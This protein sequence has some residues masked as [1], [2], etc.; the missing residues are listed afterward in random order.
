MN[1]LRICKPPFR[2]NGHESR[3]DHRS[4]ADRGIA[5]Q[6]EKHLGWKGSKNP[7]FKDLILEYRESMKSLN[8]HV[9]YLPKHLDK[10]DKEQPQQQLQGETEQAKVTIARRILE[11]KLKEQ[12]RSPEDIKQVIDQFNKAMQDPKNVEKLPSAE[13][14]QA[15]EIKYEQ[16]QSKGIER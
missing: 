6:P 3:V 14:K 9:Y 11:E 15:K 13:T 5:Q 7:Q 10:L 2:K 4:N 8:A 12:N 16:Q 1:A